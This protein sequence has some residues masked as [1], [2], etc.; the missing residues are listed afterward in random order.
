MSPEA[1]DARTALVSTL[2]QAIAGYGADLLLAVPKA[3]VLAVPKASAAAAA[4]PARL[5]PMPETSAAVAAEATALVRPQ[6]TPPA[7][8]PRERER[9]GVPGSSPPLAPQPLPSPTAAAPSGPR[10]G[11]RPA[12][13]PVPP[14]PSSPQDPL[15]R[16]KTEVLACKKCKL[17]ETRKAVVF[18]EGTHTPEVMFVGEAPGAVEDQTGRPFVGPAG[19]LL[20]RILDGAMGLRREDVFIANVNKCRPPGNRD[21]EP[22]EV[23]ACLPYLRQQVELLQPKVLVALGRVA[24]HNLLDT[25]APMRE[26]R[27]RE[28]HYLG[29]PVVVTWHPAYL[30]RDPSRKVE[31][32][33][34]IKRVNRLLGRPEDPRRTPPAE[35]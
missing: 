6:P 23:A 16:L 26:L 29:I 17:C 7:P 1:M 8:T 33:A 25:Q 13:A 24:A 18:G 28:L 22:D 27:G 19:Q 30:L 9:T 3:N 14:E 5:E 15:H 12:P 10:P 2:Q 32:W 35:A 21:P 31:T 34:D 11:E 20:D 4:P